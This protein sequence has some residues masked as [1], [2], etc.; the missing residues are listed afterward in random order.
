MQD[1][2]HA[3]SL[4]RYRPGCY[5]VCPQCGK[6]R[7]KLYVDTATEQPLGDHIG[8]CERLDNCGHHFTPREYFVQSPDARAKADQW[9]HS[10]AWRTVHEPPKPLD[11]LPRDIM[12]KTQHLLEQNN[13][14][15]YLA[16]IFGW[17]QALELSTRYN[18]G[19]SKMWKDPHGGL[20]VVFW[21]VDTQG[22]LRQGKV[23]AYDP[24]T[25]R[26]VKEGNK[27]AF[28]GK[29]IHPDKD[30]A[31]LVQ[32]LFGE[33]LLPTMPD[34]P[35]C[36]VESEKTAIICAG[37]V[38]NVVWLATGGKH[39]CKWAERDVYKVLKGRNVTL[40]PDLGAWDVWANKAKLLATVCTVVVSRL[41][42]D[43]ATDEQRAA[44][45][46][47]ADQLAEWREC[48]PM[49]HVQPT[50]DVIEGFTAQVPAEGTNVTDDP[51][52]APTAA[53]PAG[54][55][56]YGRTVEVDGLPMGWLNN[57]EL[58]DAQAR[59]RGFELAIFA[60][61]NPDVMGLVGRFGLG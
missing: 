11:C 3:Y 20:S 21:Q 8:K 46:D 12:A 40:Y 35:V 43:H 54:F 44:G 15:R 26:R 6:R 55:S 42:E 30:R 5:K 29:S 58:E 24:T 41:V 45:H 2:T 14:C 53:L 13:F 60:A 1:T 50:G 17:E 4:Q 38:P 22:R 16:E 34:A 36:I 57:D 18:L 27:T 28:I 47:L 7:F 52:H 59:A 39:G 19:S 33:H 56:V 10:D 49:A 23:M 9:L 31:N 32:C 37:Y 61:T 48:A 25:G 51:Q